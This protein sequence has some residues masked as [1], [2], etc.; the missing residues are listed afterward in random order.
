[1][2]Q[3][4]RLRRCSKYCVGGLSLIAT[5]NC[6]AEISQDQLERKEPVAARVPG[7]ETG[8][9]SDHLT[10][11]WN[12]IRSVLVELG[13]H[14]SAGYTGEA[15]ANVSGGLS[16]GAEYAGLFEMAL[17]L[18]TY[19]LGLQEG[20]LF[21]IS[22]LHP[23]GSSLSRRR[24]GD[25]QTLSNI[26]AFDS[27][28]LYDFWFQQSFLDE[29]VSIRVGQMAAD[30]EFAYTEPGGYFM[31]SSF[32]WPAFI[33]ANTVNTGP[34]FFVAAPGIRLR[35]DPGENFFLQ[36]GIF[37][38]DTFDSP[39]GDPRPNASG[40]RIHLGPEQG[41]FSIYEAGFKVNPSE[42]EDGLAGMYKI[43][44]WHHSGDFAD[45]FRDETGGAAVV[46][47]GPARM[48]SQ[49]YGAYA[50][51]E[52]M[53][54]REEA[55]KGDGLA[56]FARAGVSP[57]DRSLFDFTFDGGLLYSGLLPGRDDDVAGLGVAY[58]RV[59]NDIARSERADRDVNGTTYRAI[60]DHETVIE[61]FYQLQL[62][63]WWLLQPDVQY[64]IHPG[65]SSAIPNAL[66]IGIRTSLS[67]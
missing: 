66:V 50:A 22:S 33:S 4:K 40:T 52:Q 21:K 2:N 28:R 42:A 55:G 24:I 16:R 32:G 64:I 36:A 51:G 29:R 48:H 59:S 25:L 19:R 6:V 37:D 27:F 34:A 31:N 11:N 20:G 14:L 60:S 49:N 65:G 7:G 67:F 13:I 8:L 9:E 58:A 45:N 39:T 53:L 61:A 10:G 3:M 56:I 41:Y 44:A 1:M 46:T 62:R 57:S 35:V 38:G 12:G 5:V 47:G 17:E 23:H 54:Y 43:G 26:D 30:E 18:D 63:K 15:L